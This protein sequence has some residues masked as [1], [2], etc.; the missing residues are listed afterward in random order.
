MALPPSEAGVVQL[1]VADALPAVAVAP[2]GASGTVG[3]GGGAM[4][5]TALE[6]A[7][8]ALFPTAFVAATV[9]V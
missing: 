5:V 2:V 3:D 8:G 9:K 1:T 4:G 7:L 6:A